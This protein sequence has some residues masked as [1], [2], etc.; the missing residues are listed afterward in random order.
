MQNAVIPIR[1]VKQLDSEGRF[2]GY[3][4]VYDVVDLVGDVVERGAY[5][6]TIAERPIVKILFNHNANLPI[7]LG[8]LEDSARGLLL[9]G[10][11]N[12]DVSTARE[13]YSNLKR[14][15]LDAL[16]IGYEVRKSS[17]RA[18]GVRVLKDISVFEVS[19]VTFPANTA[20]LIIDVKEH[21]PLAAKL[22]GQTA[23][24]KADIRRIQAAQAQTSWSVTFARLR[25]TINRAAG[26]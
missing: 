14:G 3:A 17:R 19:L 25:A 18:D 1:F 10:E 2:T 12:L 21:Q 7:G 4:S 13:V 6:R 20:A 11:L 16:S 8:R 22:R 23:A 5:T 9:H 15:V 24:M 26:R